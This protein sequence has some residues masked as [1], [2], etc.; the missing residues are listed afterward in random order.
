MFL[1]Q[2]GRIYFTALKTHGLNSVVSASC[3]YTKIQKQNVQKGR[4]RLVDFCPDAIQGFRSRINEI[5]CHFS[6]LAGFADYQGRSF[7]LIRSEV[8][9]DQAKND[10]FENIDLAACQ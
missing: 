6:Q 1:F 8:G 5:Q 10:F 4:C 9:P 2:T 7:G 3:V